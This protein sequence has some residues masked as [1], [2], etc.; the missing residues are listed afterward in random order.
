MIGLLKRNKPVVVNFYTDRQDVFDYYKIQ[1]MNHFIPQWFKDIDPKY[2]VDTQSLHTESNMRGC[3]GFMGLF[4]KGFGVPLWSDL[5]VKLSP[6][7]E[8][9]YQ[10]LFSDGET[11]AEIH[12]QA[13]RGAFMPDSEYAHLKI[14]TPWAARCDEDI[15]FLLTPNTWIQENSDCVVIPQGT[16]NFKYQ[17]STNINLMFKR[18]DGESIVDLSCAT[19]IVQLIPLTERKVI[20]KHH[21]VTTEELANLKR[22]PARGYFDRGYLKHKARA[23]KCPFK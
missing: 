4:A 16:I 23:K 10:W 5:R 22:I 6:I 12:G 3:A 8:K 13:Q 11:V 18:S 15:E 17:F 7:G 9:S 1:P 19:P 14:E 2:K 20:A 21:L